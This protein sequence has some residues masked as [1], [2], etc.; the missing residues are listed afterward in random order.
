MSPYLI[1]IIIAKPRLRSTVNG[2]WKL[3]VFINSGCSNSMAKIMKHDAAVTAPIARSCAGIK[4]FRKL[5]LPI[6]SL[7][8]D[9]NAASPAFHSF[10][11]R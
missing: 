6:K 3:V 5:S 9:S 2:V 1:F 10:Y 11:R 7:Q 4:S 8:A